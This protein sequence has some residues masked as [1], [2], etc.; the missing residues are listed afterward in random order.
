VDNDLAWLVVGRFGRPHGI[1]GFITVHSFTEPRDN[2]LQYTN[3]HAVLKQQRQPL[4]LLQIETND[5]GILVQ[6]AGYP[7]R[8]QVANLTNLDIAVSAVQLP[9]L[10]PGDYYWHEL[11][12]MEVISAQG[13]TL[14][15]VIEILSTGSNDVLVIE[16]IKRHLIPYLPG[17]FVLEVNKEQKLIKVDWDMDF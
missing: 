5:K 9:S 17:R 13:S 6:V 4:D 1:K 2:I 16:G 15:K 10:Q 7:E 14:G 11:I 12:G 3:W 8:E